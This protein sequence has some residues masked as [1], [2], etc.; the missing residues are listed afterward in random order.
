MKKEE[1]SNSSLIIT[2]KDDEMDKEKEEMRRATEK[3][4]RKSRSIIKYI[5]NTDTLKI[6]VEKPNKVLKSGENLTNW[7]DM[8]DDDGE[9]R[10]VYLEEVNVAFLGFKLFFFY[11]LCVLDCKTRRERGDDNKNERRLLIISK[12]KRAPRLRPRDRA[13]R[14]SLLF[15][16]L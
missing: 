2:T 4:N 8:F 13:L 9:L 10:E 3:M 14:F 16:N 11:N 5:D 7:E 1:T 6:E 12:Q 15:Q